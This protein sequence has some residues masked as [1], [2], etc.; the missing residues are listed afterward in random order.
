M[1]RSCAISPCEPRQ[2]GNVASLNK[3][4]YVPQGSFNGVTC[5]V[6]ASVKVF[7]KRCT[8]FLFFKTAKSGLL[9]NFS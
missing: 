5:V 4:R 9:F 3:L 1:L 2:D 7:E 6:T 8:A